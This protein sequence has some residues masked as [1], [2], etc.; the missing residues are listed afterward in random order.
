MGLFPLYSQD[1]HPFCLILAPPIPMKKTL[2]SAGKEN[3]DYCSS[4]LFCSEQANFQFETKK[5]VDRWRKIC[6]VGDTTMINNVQKTLEK[7]EDRIG[8]IILARIVDSIDLVALKARY[9][10]DCR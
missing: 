10:D 3:F 9:Y 6:L 5:N 2:R 8:S 1:D 7:H 4:C